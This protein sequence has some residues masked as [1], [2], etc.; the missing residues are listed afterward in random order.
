MKTDEALEEIN[1]TH[2]EAWSRILSKANPSVDNTPLSPYM[3]AFMLEK[4]SFAYNGDKIKKILGYQLKHPTFGSNTVEETIDYFK[5]EGIWP[6]V[7]WN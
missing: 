7:Q 3:E 1:E 2:I 5:E 4:R 6:N